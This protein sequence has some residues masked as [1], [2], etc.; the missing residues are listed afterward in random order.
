[1]NGSAVG[2]ATCDEAIDAFATVNAGAVP[3]AEAGGEVR[4]SHDAAEPNGRG[5]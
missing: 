4:L 5:E 3:Q 1:M 2:P